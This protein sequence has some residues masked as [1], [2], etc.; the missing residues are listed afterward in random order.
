MVIPARAA[1]QYERTWDRFNEMMSFI[2]TMTLRSL[3]RDSRVNYCGM[4]EWMA[5][6]LQECIKVKKT[7]AGIKFYPYFSIEFDTIY[8]A[9]TV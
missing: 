9:D 3:C 8:Y 5:L 2:P 1:K 7:F 6:T 4:Q